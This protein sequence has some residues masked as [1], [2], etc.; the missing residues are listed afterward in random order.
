MEQEKAEI[1]PPDEVWKAL[2]ENG[3]EQKVGKNVRSMTNRC[4][5]T[6]FNIIWQGG[7]ILLLA[8]AVGLAVN[9]LRPGGL[10]LAA[11]WS[12][13]A[14][15]MLDNGGSLEISLEEAETLF[16]ARAALFLD[17][18]SPDLFG[19]GHI[20]GAHNLPWEEFGR[21]LPKVMAG[22]S[23]DRPIITYCD[24]EGCGLSK[25]LA[26]ALLGQGYNNVRVLANGWTLWL[27]NGLPTEA[28][29]AGS[30]SNLESTR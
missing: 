2:K 24:G 6:W 5:R 30:Q 12:P 28:I 4:A 9:Q 18:R 16:F 19:E 21:Y 26:T 25:E 10:P 29:S 27:E 13:A 22:V 3:V 8:V 11:D 23:P 1:H 7:A 17:A 14:Q 20:E 15:L